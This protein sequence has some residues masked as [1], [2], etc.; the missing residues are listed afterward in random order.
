MFRRA[1]VGLRVRIIA[2]RNQSAVGITGMVI[3][4]SKYMLTVKT[5][6]GNKMVHKLGSIFEL[7]VDDK[8]VIIDGTELKGRIEERLK[9]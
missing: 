7:L 4:D 5:G 9:R 3:F 6:T 1:V 8:K 2:A